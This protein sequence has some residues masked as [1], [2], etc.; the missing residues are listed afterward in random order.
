MGG[1]GIHNPSDDTNLLAGIAAILAVLVIIDDEIEI[2]DDEIED[3]QAD[4]TDIKAVT[5]ILPTLSETG[6]TV[7]TDGTEQNVYVNANPLG[8][9]NPIAVVINF[10]AQQAGEE[11]TLRLYYDNAPGGAGLLLADELSFV[12]VIAPAMI[13][14]NMEP[15]R[16]VVSVT[17]ERTVGAARA[18]P[19]DVHYEI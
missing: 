1:E 15:N 14:V 19:W 4:V 5:D 2:I 3:L 8:E 16:Y 10:T 11:T 18:Y 13:V 7:T 6:G 12:G 17:I 9:F